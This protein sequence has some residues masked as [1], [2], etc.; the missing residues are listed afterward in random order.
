MNR[1]YKAREDGKK[2]GGSF[3]RLLRF[4]IMKSNVKIQDFHLNQFGRIPGTTPGIYTI[5]NVSL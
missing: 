1:G 2:C 5:N 3:Q 4:R